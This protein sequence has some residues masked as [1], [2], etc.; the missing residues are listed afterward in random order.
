MSKKQG[1][2]M[3]LKKTIITTIVTLSSLFSVVETQAQIIR[4]SV[5]SEEVVELK[6]DLVFPVTK[7]SISEY[8]DYK[9]SSPKGTSCKI[10]LPPS[11]EVRTLSKGTKFYFSTRSENSVDYAFKD[12]KFN[13][14]SGTFVV[15]VEMGTN[16]TVIDLKY[17]GES[18][19]KKISEINDFSIDCIKNDQEKLFA[20]FGSY[21]IE[22][23][24]NHPDIDDD[25]VKA[26]RS[27][28]QGYYTSVVVSYGCVDKEWLNKRVRSS[29][30]YY[31]ALLYGVIDV[32]DI[33]KIH[34]R[35]FKTIRINEPNF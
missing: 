16:S 21:V 23:P 14:G 19:N 1:K 33:T 4:S 28:N 2:T 11:N 35:Y 31:K 10:T 6:Q 17:F 8:Y 30:L 32:G 15:G 24:E 12:I 20:T 3:N 18:T 22:L 34:D 26:A 13:S 9:I 7:D 25:C 29:T 5:S 27:Y